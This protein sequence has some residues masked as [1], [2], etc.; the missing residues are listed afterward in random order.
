MPVQCNVA[1]VSS[2]T[3]ATT[4]QV[5]MGANYPEVVVDDDESKI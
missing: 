5:E 1:D 4:S 3:S 2:T